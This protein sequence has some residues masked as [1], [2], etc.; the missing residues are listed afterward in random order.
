MVIQLLRQILCHKSPPRRTPLAIVA[1]LWP[2][3]T[4]HV[5]SCRIGTCPQGPYAPDQPRPI[6]SQ[7]LQIRRRHSVKLATNLVAILTGRRAT[8]PVECPHHPKAKRP[9]RTQR[10]GPSELRPDL[11]QGCASKPTQEER[12]RAHTDGTDALPPLSRP[13]SPL[14]FGS[15]LSQ[16]FHDA[17]RD[18]GEV[19]R[20]PDEPESLVRQEAL[21]H[22]VRVVTA[23]E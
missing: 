17:A 20:F 2:C 21:V 15:F 19:E 14:A 4:I 11:P 10:S 3:S 18:V 23:Y 1:P 5:T 13:S 12:D 6:N 7:L 8:A 22:S 16:E 9:P